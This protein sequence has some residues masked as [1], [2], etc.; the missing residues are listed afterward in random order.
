MGISGF[1]AFILS[2]LYNNWC[3]L[4]KYLIIQLCVDGIWT[5]NL[6]CRK[7]PFNQL[8]PNPTP[9]RKNRL[10]QKRQPARG[11]WALSDINPQIGALGSKA[12]G[13]SAE[14]L[15]GQRW[16]WAAVQWGRSGMEQ[17]CHRGLWMFVCTNCSRYDLARSKFFR[18]WRA[19]VTWP[20]GCSGATWAPTGPGSKFS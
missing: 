1:F 7:R 19:A 18:T 8:S 3:I 20:S 15:S 13:S 10:G 12:L 5:A 6:W 2:E 11:I 14:V 16:H 9:Q 17:Q 4:L